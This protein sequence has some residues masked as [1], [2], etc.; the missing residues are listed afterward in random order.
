MLALL[1]DQKIALH[2]L[3]DNKPAFAG[4]EILAA[5]PKSAPLSHCIVHQPVM[6]AD[7][8]SG[9]IDYISGLS[10]KKISSW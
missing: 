8:S 3:S 7:N 1:N 6:P 10:G 4:A 2:I 5:Y 9:Q